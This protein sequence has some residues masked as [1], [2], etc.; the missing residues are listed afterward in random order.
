MNNKPD[1]IV[2]H[3]SYLLVANIQINTSREELFIKRSL[4]DESAHE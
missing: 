3:I 4:Y 2:K 1:L